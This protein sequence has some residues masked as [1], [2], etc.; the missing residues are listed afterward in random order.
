MMDDAKTTAKNEGAFKIEVRA[1]AV[2][3]HKNWTPITVM[4]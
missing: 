2:Q 4:G 1:V 3:T